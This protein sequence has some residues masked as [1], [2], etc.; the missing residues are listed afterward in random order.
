[1]SVSYLHL[2]F[3]LSHLISCQHF[4]GLPQIKATVS[5]TMF[6]QMKSLIGG[7]L[8]TMIRVFR[9]FGCNGEGHI[10]QHEFC[11]IL[12]NYCICLTEE[13]QRSF[14]GGS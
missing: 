1:M 6:A 8:M 14:S 9:L 7:N 11:R 2:L 13:F 12:D 4:S 5:I 3:A 10:R